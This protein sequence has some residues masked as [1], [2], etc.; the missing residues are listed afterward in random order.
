MVKKKKGLEK[1]AENNIEIIR[2][3]TEKDLIDLSLGR[4]PITLSKRYIKSFK[5]GLNI[6]YHDSH[7][8]IYKFTLIKSR[9]T[10][11]KYH[12]IIDFNNLLRQQSSNDNDICLTVNSIDTQY[13]LSNISHW[14]NCKSGARTVNPC[15]HIIAI[16][17]LIIM[18][19]DKKYNPYKKK[20][21]KKMKI[22]NFLYF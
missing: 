7:P 21:K 13:K 14:C 5:T 18:A 20:K 11:K 19:R 16:L 8:N 9:H 2:N 3:W 22:D 6:W 17:R 12:G 1:W 4:W 15:A 10:S